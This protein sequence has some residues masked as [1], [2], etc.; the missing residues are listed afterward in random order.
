M[1]GDQ[2]AYIKDV[3]RGD[4]PAPVLNLIHRETVCTLFCWNARGQDCFFGNY[5]SALTRRHMGAARTRDTS[6]AAI[7]NWASYASSP[8]AGPAASGHHTKRPWE[9]RFCASQYPWPSYVS[10]RIAAPLRLRNTNTH[11]E[12]GS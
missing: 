7:S 8:L 9:S 12:N 11:P 1:R 4:R 3:F 5:F 10:K 2:L 6:P